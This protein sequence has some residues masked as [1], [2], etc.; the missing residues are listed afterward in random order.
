M[1]RNAGTADAGAE[2]RAV[3][4]ERGPA[5]VAAHDLLP[6]PGR[7]GNRPDHPVVLEPAGQQAGY[8]R[9]GRGQAIE[10][11][12]RKALEL[13]VGQRRVVAVQV[14]FPEVVGGYQPAV[15]T[16]IQPAG[17][18]RAGLEDQSVKVV[19]HRRAV[20]LAPASPPVRGGGVLRD[21]H[22]VL[23]SDR[24][25]GLIGGGEPLRRCSCSQ[26]VS[27]PS[28]PASAD[29]TRG[30]GL[31]AAPLWVVTVPATDAQVRPLSAEVQTAATV[32]S[33]L[34]LVPVWV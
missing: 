8:R 10:L 5:P 26:S 28:Q 22:A 27:L 2:Q 33:R 18:R 34:S 32:A 19:V 13:Q 24:D 15:R 17:R 14:A 9:A 6:L 30:T 12:F 4:Q 7:A 23:P 1:D 20:V 25:G 21:E 11:A 29:S 3:G 31:I 16:D